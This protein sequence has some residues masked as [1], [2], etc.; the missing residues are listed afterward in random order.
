M[1]KTT[2]QKQLAIARHGYILISIL[3]YISGLV[4][5]IAPNAN[6]TA[7]AITGSIILILYGIIK[8]TGYLS[9]DLYCLAFQHD[10]ACGL[11][12][13]VLGII[14]LV[15]HAKFKGYLL[16]ALGILVL[17]D[18]LLC[19]QTSIDAQRFGLPSWQIILAA[20]ILSGVLGVVLIIINTQIVAGCCLLAEG[21]LH[22]YIIQCTVSSSLTQHH[23][24]TP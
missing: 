2:A 19:I 3:F 12:L 14:G 10:F 18:S 6:P 4:C 24:S 16:P 5:I 7:A 21:F 23:K 9:K 15:L 22:H 8:I 13:I 11:L 20:A 1:S 17:V